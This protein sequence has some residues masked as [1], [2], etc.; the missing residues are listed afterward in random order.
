MTL[1]I[2]YNDP[3]A[4]IDQLQELEDAG[5]SRVPVGTTGGDPTENDR[6]LQRVRISIL[7]IAAAIHPGRPQIP[8]VKPL[9]AG[10]TARKDKAARPRRRRRWIPSRVLGFARLSSPDYSTPHR[11]TNE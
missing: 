9:A 3:E 6:D 5:V 8:G 1:E 2:Y 4:G 11:P 7:F 10:F